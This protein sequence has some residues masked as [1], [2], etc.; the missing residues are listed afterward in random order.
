MNK[1]LITFKRY[2]PLLYE[3]VKRDIKLKYRNSFL[4]ILWSMINPLMTMI[5]LT[6]IFSNIFKNSIVNFPVYCLSGRLLYDFFSQSTN[7]SMK[8]ITGKSSLIKKIYVPKYIYPLSKVMSTFIIFIISL[9][10]LFLVM[11]L[12]GV[13]FSYMNLFI[14]YPLVTL[15][16]ISFGIGLILATVNVFFRDMEH[17]YSVVLLIVMYMSAIFYSPNIVD[18]RFVFFMKLNPIYPAICIFRDCILN[19]YITSMTNIILCAFY[20]LIYLIIGLF[21]FYK[22]QDKFI[23]Y[24]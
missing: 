10:P 16:I 24:I 13:K 14:V 18:S 6:F 15:F 3:F 5:V 8:S 1:Y 23:L 11:I 4:G 22:K 19:G 17:I 12:T 7:Q 21:I 20:S 2:K 9:I